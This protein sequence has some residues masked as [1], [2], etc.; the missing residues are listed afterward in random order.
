MKEENGMLP[1]DAAIAA[2]MESAAEG[3]GKT[4]KI[5]E[6]NHDAWQYTQQQCGEASDTEGNCKR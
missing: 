6:V 1:C 4:G 3:T 5:T 2:R